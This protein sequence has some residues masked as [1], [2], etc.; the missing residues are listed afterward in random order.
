MEGR[1]ISTNINKT[2]TPCVT[3]GM[4][5]DMIDTCYQFS[6]ESHTVAQ[7]HCGASGKIATQSLFLKFI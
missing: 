1:I 3:E 7:W 2:F 6:Y 4:N 5:R